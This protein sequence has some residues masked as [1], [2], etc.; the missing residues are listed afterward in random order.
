MSNTNDP[1]HELSKIYNPTDVEKK[2]YQEWEKAK[3]F[4]PK[5]INQK[6]YTLMFI[7]KLI[8]R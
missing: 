8:F 2:W 1:I 7:G 5:D 4:D 6:S 3:A